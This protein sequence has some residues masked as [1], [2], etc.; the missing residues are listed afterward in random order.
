MDKS[1]SIPKKDKKPAN[2][3]NRSLL[4][5]IR[6]VHGL[7]REAG[8]FLNDRELLS[9]NRCGLLEDVDITGR[10]ITYKSGEAVFD[11][12]MRF[13]KGERDTQ[14]PLCGAPAREG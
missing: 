10:L 1:N 4:R 12:G 2:I 9:C 14:C 7:A 6:H 8:I 11:S 3:L 5:E 13:E